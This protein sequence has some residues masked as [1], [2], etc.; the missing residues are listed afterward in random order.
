MAAVGEVDINKACRKVTLAVRVTGMRRFNLRAS[1]TLFL[2]RLARWTSPVPMELKVK[3]P[4]RPRARKV[5]K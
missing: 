5:S 3:K 4:A 1:V 2:L